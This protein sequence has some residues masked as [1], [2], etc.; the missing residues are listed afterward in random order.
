MKEIKTYRDLMKVLSDGHTIEARSVY[1]GSW[2]TINVFQFYMTRIDEELLCE[3]R[4]KP[5]KPSIDWSQV[6]DEYRYLA[7]DM[8]GSVFLYKEKPETVN[9][10]WSVGHPD[11]INASIFKSLEVGTCDWRD[12]LVKRPKE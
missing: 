3:Y 2:E 10:S 1:G 11:F 8:S 9:Y 7:K 5:T 12:S 6:S 4:I